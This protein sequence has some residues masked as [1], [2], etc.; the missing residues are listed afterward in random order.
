MKFDRSPCEARV[1]GN[2]AVD[3]RRL[4]VD[5]EGRTG[6]F[7]GFAER[8]QTVEGIDDVFEGRNDDARS[9]SGDLI[10]VSADIDGAADDTI[11][12]EI[13]DVHSGGV[14]RRAKDRRVVSGITDEA[15]RTGVDGDRVR[16]ELEVERSGGLEARID[17]RILNAKDV[18]VGAAE[19]FGVVRGRNTDDARR[20]TEL[21]EDVKVVIIGGRTVFD[22]IL[23]DD[24][25]L[26]RNG[27]VSVD[28]GDARR[29]VLRDR[30]IEH[31]DGARSGVDRAARFFRFIVVNDDV[32]EFDLTAG[33]ID[34]AAARR[35]TASQRD[36]HK[37]E[38]A[39]CDVE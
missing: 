13:I 25:V 39:A 23:G 34:R 26:E 3:N 14:A 17:R 1:E 32:S 31:R 12:A 10:F 37:L 21:T 35:G 16:I 24:R 29:V 28:A 20:R 38:L 5:V 4:T 8:N 19:G 6:V 36:V 2:V 18:A 33:L 11:V 9:F 30:R 15:V 7:D 27:S 22:G